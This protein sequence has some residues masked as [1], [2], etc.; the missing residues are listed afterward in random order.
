VEGVGALILTVR[1]S[2]EM[3]VLRAFYF[4][5][6]HAVSAFNNA[7][8]PCSRELHL[9]GVPDGPDRQPDDHD[10]DCVGR[11]RISRLSRYLGESAWQRFRL[12]TH[13]KLAVLVSVLLIVGGTVGIWAFE[14][15]NE[16]NAGADA[17]R[18]SGPCGL[19]SFDLGQ[20]GGFNTI[21]IGLVG[22]ATL[23]FLILLMII[24][25]SR[26]GPEAESRRR[27]SGSS[28]RRSGRR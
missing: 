12:S 20:D 21:D 23:Y 27:L 2:F 22:T 13:T 8:S 10:A 26:A 9:A 3:D 15:Q 24:G 14:V 6:F 4:G 19:L 25:A 1:F 11:D 5:V 28:A 16:K 7:G 18:R 17:P